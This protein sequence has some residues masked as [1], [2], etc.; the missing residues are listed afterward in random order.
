MSDSRVF[1]LARGAR[2]QRK[3]W[4]GRGFASGTQDLAVHLVRAHEVGDDRFIISDC[5][6]CTVARFARLDF[7]IA[8]ILAFR[9]ALPQALRYH[10]LRG[11]R[12]INDRLVVIKPC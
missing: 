12:Q 11:L 2:H 3:A 10:T 7:M 1:I 4:G 5:G 9:S 6:V 8:A